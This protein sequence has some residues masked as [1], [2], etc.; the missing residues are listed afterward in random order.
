MG[1]AYRGLAVACALPLVFFLA[2]PLTPTAI[3]S[4]APAS[5]LRHDLFVQIDPERHALVATDRLTVELPQAGPAQFSLA[6]PLQ[7]DCLVLV[8]SPA[9]PDEPARDLPF[10]IDR[11]TAPDSPQRVTVP[12]AMLSAGTI[13]LTAYYHGTINDP[14]KE[15]RHLR[16]VTPSETAGHIGPEGVYLSSE[17]QWYLDVGES[18]TEY[19]LRVAV[20][21]GWTAVS[22]GKVRR[23][24]ACPPDLCSQ[25]GMMLAEWEPIPPTEALTLVANRFVAKS[26]EW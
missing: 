18:L 14:P 1:Y 17:S 25:P 19:R 21:A 11:H 23:S 2:Q 16:F 5:I 3:A 22:Q 12:A 9:S 26:R 20:P 4:D 24:G 7:L 8:A 10:E 15:P 6:P 13:S